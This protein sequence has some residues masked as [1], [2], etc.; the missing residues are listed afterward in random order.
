MAV[1]RLIC[2]VAALFVTAPVWAQEEAVEDSGPWS[3]EIAAGYLASSGNTDTTSGTARAKLNYMVGDWENWVEG[4]AFGSSDDEGTTAE[5]YQVAGRSLYNFSEK[6]YGYGQLEW[7]KNRFSAYTQQTF[8]TVGYGRRILTS[9]KY[10]LNLEVGAGLTQQKAVIS[11]EPTVTENERGAVYVAAGE[12]I[13]QVSDTTQFEQLASAN[14]AS[15]N[16]YWETISRISV[17][18]VDS[19]ALTVSYTIQGNTDVSDD[20]EKTDRFTAISLDYAF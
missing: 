2:A 14:V 17:S 8:E 13:W 20:V 16:T 15:D 12:F 5:A 19:L 18:V 3:G 1:R 10:K 7:R 9:D 11:S 6:N 4:K